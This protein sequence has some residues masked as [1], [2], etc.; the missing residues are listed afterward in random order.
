[1]NSGTTKKYRMATMKART[2]P[3]ADR[4]IDA[5]PQE[6]ADCGS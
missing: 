5:L 2:I 6:R 4:I 3:M 1:M